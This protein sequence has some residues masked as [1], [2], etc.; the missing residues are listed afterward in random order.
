MSDQD[1]K[2][3]LATIERLRREQ[4]ATPEQARAVLIA[5]GILDPN[6]ELA[7]PYRS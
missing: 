4:A 5:E 3:F 1:L 7:E 6:G 2:D